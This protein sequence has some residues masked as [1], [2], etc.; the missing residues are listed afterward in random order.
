MK[1]KKVTN[2]AM[3]IPAGLGM[4]LLLSLMMTIAG[5]AVTALLL[6]KEV[7]AESSVG[8]GAVLTLI[9]SSVAGALLSAKKIKRLR[10]QMTLVFGACYYVLLLCMTALLF[11]GQYEGTGMTALVVLGSSIAVAIGGLGGGTRKKF[12][13]KPKVY[14]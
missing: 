2:T 9:I 4:G 11:G 8:Y 7:L 12:H 3:S 1:K 14:R 10:L 5:A 6:N 13:G